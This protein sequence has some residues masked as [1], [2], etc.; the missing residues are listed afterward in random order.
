M[1]SGEFNYVDEY[2]DITSLGDL[3]LADCARV[4]EE[5]G[6][7]ACDHLAGSPKDQLGCYGY[8]ELFE[9]GCY[10]R[11]DNDAWTSWLNCKV[12]G[13]SLSSACTSL[14]CMPQLHDVQL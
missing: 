12:A 10:K 14:P 9:G 8:F 1:K 5:G 4:C 2:C 7:V 13:E 6:Y 3:T 11:N